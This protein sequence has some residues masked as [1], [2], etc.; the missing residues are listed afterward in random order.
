MAD[1]KAQAASPAV[2]F[3][4]ILASERELYETH[5]V[6]VELRTLTFSEVQG[7]ATRNKG[8]DTEIAF[9][10]L[11]L[12]LMS[13]EL[14]EEQWG[15]VRDGKSGPLMRIAQRVMEISGMVQS[16]GNGPLDGTGS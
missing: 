15:L 5:G 16:E 12:G 3:L 6:T 1:T 10:A 4:A 8:N 14:S 11:R 2:D 13:P 9:Q 7:I